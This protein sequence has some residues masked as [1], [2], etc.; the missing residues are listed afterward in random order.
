MP[1]SEPLISV[2]MGVRYR[3]ESLDLLERS[4]QSIL[5]QTLKNFEL[6]ICDD[7]SSLATIKYLDSVSQDESRV[8]LIRNP[9]CLDLA[10][11]LNLCLKTARGEYIARMDDDDYSH[12]DRLE[13]QL[14]FLLQ[15]KEITFV[16]CNVA[17]IQNEINIGIRKLPP[18]PT[19]EDF[20]FVQPYIHPTLLFRREALAAAQGYSE[21]KRQT[22]CEDY[23]LLLRLYAMGYQGANLQ[24][25]LLDYTI[26][27]SGQVNRTMSHRWNETVTRYHR[28]KD[29]HCLPQALPWVL[30]PLAVGLIPEPILRWI[31]HRLNT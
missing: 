4:I 2:I 24:V 6:L 20:Y 16:G 27:I 25:P 7:G 18:S 3:R 21:D 17:L 5:D 28:F 15:N 10:S 30:K 12:P 29:L 11:K 22:L 8:K 26:P 19:V 31:K 23:D 13:K 1:P 14:S 9:D